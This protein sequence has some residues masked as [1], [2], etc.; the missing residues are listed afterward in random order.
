MFTITH[1]RC[2]PYGPPISARCASEKAREKYLELT[3]EYSVEQT[4]EQQD[5]AERIAAATERFKLINEAN[6]QEREKE[7]QDYSRGRDR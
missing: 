1:L 3:R 6:R 7:G 2:N 4:P 5:R